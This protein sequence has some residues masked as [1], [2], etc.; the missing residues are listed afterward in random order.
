M[1]M[2]DELPFRGRSFCRPTRTQVHRP[3]IRRPRG[4][5][6]ESEQRACRE[7]FAAGWCAADLA[8]LYDVPDDVVSALLYRG[9]TR[10]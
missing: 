9:R 3:L 10:E 8:R 4:V 6:T 2:S 1:P 7:L 5:L